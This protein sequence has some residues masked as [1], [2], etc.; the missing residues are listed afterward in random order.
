MPFWR[1]GSV[2][3]LAALLVCLSGDRAGAG[4]YNLELLSNHAP[5]L[6]DLES[7]CYSTTSRWETNDEKAAALAHW[8][9][10]M[11]NQCDPP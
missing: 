7:F 11:G 1:A 10:V 8:F 3:L 5:D 6:T 4:V 9:G 2:S